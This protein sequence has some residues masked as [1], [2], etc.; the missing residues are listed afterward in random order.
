MAASSSLLNEGLYI[1]VVDMEWSGE[2]R[3]KK[4]IL[5][6]FFLFLSFL[7]WVRIR[8]RKA[9]S[10]GLTTTEKRGEP[11]FLDIFIYLFL[12]GVFS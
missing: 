12:L 4:R 2:K 5:S 7:S 8:P 10:P 6:L 1:K 11:F 9:P 3:R